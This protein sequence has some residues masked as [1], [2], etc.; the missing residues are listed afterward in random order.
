MAPPASAIQRAVLVAVP[1]AL[2]VLIFATPGLIGG[3]GS[4]QPTDIPAL[5]VEVTG[6]PWNGTV[7]DSA[8]LYVH[9]ALGGVPLYDYVGINLSDPTGGPSAS[10]Y[11][12]GTGA[13]VGPNWTCHEQGVPSV[14]LRLPV[15]TGASVNV[16]AL[17][18]QGSVRFRYNATVTF[19]WGAPRWTLRVL[20]EGAGSP[21]DYAGTFTD[22]MREEV[23]P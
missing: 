1:L 23:P 12:G 2:V 8:L 11:C 18:V 16:T 4:P 6:T 7:N 15:G 10:G 20:P 9:S 17:T 5:F 22:S 21:S 3:P 14:W 19:V 13:W